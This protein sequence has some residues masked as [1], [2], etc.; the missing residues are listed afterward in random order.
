MYNIT[1]WSGGGRRPLTYNLMPGQ[2]RNTR[3]N[4]FPSQTI[5]NNNIGN[6]GGCYDYGHCGCDGGSSTPKWMNWMMGIGFGTSLLGSILGMF[7][8][9]GGG[10][11]AKADTATDEFASLK[12]LYPKN[13]FSKVGDTYVCVTKDGKQIRGKSPDELLN[14]LGGG[15]DG[16]GEIKTEIRD[17]LAE[18]KEEVS[19]FN[20]IYKPN[21]GIEIEAIEDKND[22]DYKQYKVKTGGGNIEAGTTFR[23][24]SDLYAAVRNISNQPAINQQAVATTTPNA[25]TDFSNISITKVHDD[26]GQTQDINARQG[27][28]KLTWNQKDGHDD[29]TTAP[30]KIEVISSRSG[31]KFTYT[32]TQE[33]FDY[34]GKKYN[35]YQ[36][37][38]DPSQKY[39]IYNNQLLQTGDLAG[40]GTGY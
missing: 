16:A 29:K 28:S 3:V 27:T 14:K 24:I 34:N 6:F 15:D 37:A 8:G 7:G 31:N 18:V 12:T 36:K 22:P 1:G 25:Y 32:L 30:A 2:F 21:F 20:Q 23:T 13:T 11:A 39:I 4:V 38:N 17:D 19:K 10:G 26:S 35:V 33:T 40:K 5:I 9:G